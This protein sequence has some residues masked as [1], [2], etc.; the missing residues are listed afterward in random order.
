M[1][2]HELFDRIRFEQDESAFNALYRMMAVK[3]SRFASAFVEDTGAC[4]E[5]VNDVFL[6]LWLN[7][8]NLVHIGNVQVYLY[9]SVKNA[10]LNY[11]KSTSSRRQRELN[12]SGSLYFQLN[13]DPSELLISKELHAEIIKAVN[14]LPPR[15]KLIFKM[16]KEDG[17]SSKEVAGI[18]EL[19]DKTVFA[20]LAIALKRIESVIKSHL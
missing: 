16:V 20:Q 15:C 9:I 10:C 18:L 14:D 8:F 4:K 2:I 12:A 5:L 1:N 6:R 13:A 17:L 3:L 19:S 7:R 11:I